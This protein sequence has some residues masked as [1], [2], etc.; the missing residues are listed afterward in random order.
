MSELSDDKLYANGM[1]RMHD[2]TLLFWYARLDMVTRHRLI[3]VA[4]DRD[5]GSIIAPNSLSRVLLMLITSGAYR[6]ELIA[7]EQTSFI[8]NIVMH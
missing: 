3:A 4:N 5:D 6:Q 8:R 2:M 7:I 1:E